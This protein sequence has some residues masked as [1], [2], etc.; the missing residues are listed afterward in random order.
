MVDTLEHSDLTSAGK[1]ALL[2]AA[3]GHG[4]ATIF[5][6]AEPFLRL[7]RA[8]QHLRLS[9]PQRQFVLRVA[10]RWI[11]GERPPERRVREK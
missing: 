10:D 6:N 5:E 4:N 8:L 11:G 1:S 2:E 9:A 3:V 7:N